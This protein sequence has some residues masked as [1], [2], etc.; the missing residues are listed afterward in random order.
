MEFSL[1][2]LG[3]AII[4]PLLFAIVNHT[5][6]MLVEK[7]ASHWGLVIFSSLFGACSLALALIIV[8]ITG[9]SLMIPTLQLVILIFSGFLEIIW[10]YFYLKALSLDHVAS[11]ASWF[12]MVPVLIALLSA[13]FLKEIIPLISWIGIAF[14]AAGAGILSYDWSSQGV[15]KIKPVM[16][17]I[18]SAGIV[19]IASVLYKYAAIDSVSFWVGMVWVQLGVLVT[20]LGLLLFNRQRKEFFQMMRENKKS[21]IALSTINELCNLTGL[22]L[23]LYASFHAPLHMVYS[24]GALQPLFVLIIGMILIYFKIIPYEQSPRK[25]VIMRIIAI[26]CM[27]IA[28]VLIF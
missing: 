16:Y 17:M 27:V 21:V 3:A 26:I 18:I 13:M 25:V 2:A 20:G 7:T 23:V 4:A 5:D 28:G 10:I 19:A 14:A 1:I 8:S 9:S 6:Q 24:I 15:L 12:Q 11:I 22:L